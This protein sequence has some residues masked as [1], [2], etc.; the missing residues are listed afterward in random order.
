[1]LDVAKLAAESASVVQ[2]PRHHWALMAFAGPAAVWWSTASNDAFGVAGSERSLL[3]AG[4]IA[5]TVLALVGLIGQSRLERNRSVRGKAPAFGGRTTVWRFL[6][7]LALFLP[8]AVG[9]NLVSA[10][11]V[12]RPYII[13]L[14]LFVFLAAAPSYFWT[15]HIEAMRNPK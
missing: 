12:R 3:I 7:I 14:A 2:F 13:G 15:R 4:A 8:I 10:L 11:D 6:A 9:V 1:M 5:M